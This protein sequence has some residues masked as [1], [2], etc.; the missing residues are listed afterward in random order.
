MDGYLVVVRCN[1][2]DL[3]VYLAGTYEEAERVALAAAENPDAA[4]D[5]ME[6][7]MAVSSFNHVAIVTFAAGRPVKMQAVGAPFDV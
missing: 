7:R 5:G 6:I 1:C 3:P 2:D 4:I